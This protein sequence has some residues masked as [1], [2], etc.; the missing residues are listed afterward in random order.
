MGELRHDREEKGLENETHMKKEKNVWDNEKSE[1]R[2][3]IVFL[4]LLDIGQKVVL[5]FSEFQVFEYLS[6]PLFFILYCSSIIFLNQT[7]DK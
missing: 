6:S 7:L 5:R 2:N 3:N 1:N 4:F